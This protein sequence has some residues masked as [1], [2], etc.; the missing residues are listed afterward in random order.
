MVILISSVS[1]TYNTATVEASDGT[2]KLDPGADQ[3]T[4]RGEAG[5][6]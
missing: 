5:V 2:E 3:Q 6:L 1:T 4:A